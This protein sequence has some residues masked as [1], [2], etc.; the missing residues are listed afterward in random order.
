MITEDRVCFDGAHTR[1][2]SVAGDGP[3]IALLHGFA[4][5]AETWRALL[6]EFDAAGRAAFAVDMPGFGQAAPREPG[7][8]M[9][10]LDAFVDAMI[11]A[12]GPVILMGNSLGAC[13]SVRAAARGS[14]NVRTAIAV[15]EPILASHWLMRLARGRTDPLRV[16]ERRMP[17]PKDLYHRAV[18]HTL[19]RLLY[20]DPARADPDVLARF[21]VQASDPSL[22]RALLGDAR[23]VA[24][25]TAGGYDSE[26]V[27]CPLLVI[28]GRKDRI[29]PVH[30]SQR[31]HESVP[32]STL[33][34]LPNSGHCP[35]LDDPSEL[36]RHVLQFIDRETEMTG[37]LK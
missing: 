16:F 25:E 9:P 4:D 23:T 11:A 32:A 5:G 22:T 20:A 31:L 21:T 29:I 12:T 18:R 2:L 1:R 27:R 28:H 33:V 3:P 14:S 19:A 30:A 24:L 17:I 6:T 15:D 36:A 8:I 7:P 10:Q 35:Q 26:H 37:R 34:V 13:V